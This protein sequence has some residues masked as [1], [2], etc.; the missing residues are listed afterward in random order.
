LE[1]YN[2]EV[3]HVLV[4]EIL[5]RVAKIRNA[6][7]ISGVIIASPLMSINLVKA[8]VDTCQW[9]GTVNGNWNNAGNWTACDGS[10][11]PE[12]GDSVIFP[13]GIVGSKITNTNLAVQL[14]NLT[15]D[16]ADVS[17]VNGGNQLIVGDTITV[18][19]N[20][21]S[22][23]ATVRLDMTSGTG[24]ITVA[25]GVTGTAFGGNISFNNASGDATFNIG[26]NTTMGSS[27]SIN[28]NLHNL[29]K[30]GNATFTPK[31]IGGNFTS[32]GGGSINISAG[33][34]SCLSGVTS[35]FGNSSNSVIIS[36]TGKLVGDPASSV[37]IA[38]PFTFSAGSHLGTVLDSGYFMTLSGAVSI[39]T[40]A[41]TF[42]VSSPG[43]LDFSSTINLNS[44]GAVFDGTTAYSP[45]ISS[46]TIN[47]VVSGTGFVTYDGVQADILPANTYGGLTTVNAN[48]WIQ[49]FSPN[50]L[51]TST[52][53]TG[54]TV[55]NDGKVVFNLSAPSPIGDDFTL[56]GDPA[57]DNLDVSPTLI[58]TITL[59]GDARFNND[60]SS[61]EVHISGKITGTGD[62]TFSR[63][64]SGLGYSLDGTSINDYTGAT[65]VSG[66]TLTQPSRRVLSF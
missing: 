13:A 22:F 34:W 38:N 14:V 46:L 3:E 4:R 62:L 39:T 7:V 44:F 2:Q 1:S 59:N 58:G 26:G 65:Y 15:I 45:T 54:G 51:G 5:T 18:N 61:D 43:R 40:N 28:G 19:A 32:N 63:T 30:L 55:I 16:D 52:P 23:G 56:S 8:A 35:C 50:G 27:G 49:L 33:N 36:G 53:V 60:S 57:I 48:T 41:A 10:G 25:N 24:G 9:T 42:V 29:F 11:V 66:T 12:D 17:I 64:N 37:T 6:I 20:N 31:S 21:A 47:G